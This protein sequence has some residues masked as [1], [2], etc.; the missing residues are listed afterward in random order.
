MSCSSGRRS[1]SR[2]GVRGEVDSMSYSSGRRSI[3]GK[4]KGY[5]GG[6]SRSSSRVVARRSSS[7]R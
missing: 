2:A 5:R 4:R 7:S 1:I 6:S 3:S